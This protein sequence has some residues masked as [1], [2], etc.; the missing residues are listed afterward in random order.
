MSTYVEARRELG[1]TGDVERRVLLWI[2]ARLPAG[3]GP[4]HLT[5]LG[6]LALVA[7]GISYALAAADPRWLHAVNL[8]LVANWLG[9]SLDGTLARFR[10]VGRPRYGFYVDHLVDGF[11]ASALLAGL[12]LSGLAHPAA[13]VA[14]LIAYLL[15]NL[16]IALAAHVT[17]VFRIARGPLGGTEL[18]MLLGLVNLAALAWPRVSVAGGELRLF[19]LVAVPASLIVAALA[20]GAGVATARRLDALDRAARAL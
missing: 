11:G 6:L 15:L 8:C 7:G 5:A 13:A 12:A 14:L 9:D 1:L 17:G 2:A 16:E 10:G 19:D 20:V 4:D 3:V 18:R